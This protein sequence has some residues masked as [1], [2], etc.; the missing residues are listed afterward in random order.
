[1]PCWIWTGC[2]DKDDYGKFR[3]AGKSWRANRWV[4][5]RWLNIRIDDENDCHHEC[6][7]RACVNPYHIREVHWSH[8]WKQ[9][10]GCPF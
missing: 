6:R 9:T 3:Y 4:I 8:R 2:Q 7:C 1:M 5:A 10:N